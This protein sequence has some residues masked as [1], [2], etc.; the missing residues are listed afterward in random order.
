MAI[1]AAQKN[2]HAG[3]ELSLMRIGRKSA[4]VLAVCGAAFFW[5]WVTGC[6][7][8]VQL[9]HEGNLRFEHC[10]R[11]DLESRISPTHRLTCWSEW[12]QYYSKDQ[13]RDRVD[14]AKR[15]IEA[16][17]SGER[18]AQP[19]NLEDVDAGSPAVLATDPAPTPTSVHKPP[20]AVLPPPPAA[21]V[22]SVEA[23]PAPEVEALP[24][25]DKTAKSSRSPKANQTPKT[26]RIQKEIPKDPGKP[27]K[28]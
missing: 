2:R 14:Y 19:L 7:P 5:I 24:A 11:L 27:T 22:P 26:P 8:S 20:P 17:R 9:I 25:V 13:T 12:I 15:R 4:P 6:G 10:Y 16:L 18:I 23:L 3:L 28:L 1:A 21:P